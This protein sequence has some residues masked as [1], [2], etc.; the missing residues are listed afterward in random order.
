VLLSIGIYAM[1]AK[2]N[3]IKIIL[4]LMVAEYAVNMLLIIVGYRKGGVPPILA[5]G[6]QSAA[7]F[8]AGAVDP[9]AQEIVLISMIISLAVLL[10]AVALAVRI[11]Q[12]YGTFDITEI[13]KL[14][15]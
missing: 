4:G 2:K 6:A 1:V 11:Y 13:R 15:G 14:R 10:V 8:R 7:D 12:K 3:V 5:G 9:V